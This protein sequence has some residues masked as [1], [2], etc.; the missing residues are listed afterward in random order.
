MTS[1]R[2]FPG[3]LVLSFV[4][5]HCKPFW[6]LLLF[7]SVG[8]CVCGFF[9]SFFFKFLPCFPFFYFYFIFLLFCFMLN[10]FIPIP[11]PQSVR[12]SDCGPPII[13]N[14]FTEAAGNHCF[15]SH[16]TSVSRKKKNK[17]KKRNVLYVMSQLLTFFSIIICL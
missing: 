16:K 14:V 1:K 17:R 6:F 13:W 15:H 12:N 9:L 4:P 7:Q 11:S 2:I 10:I 3:L 5:S 8:F